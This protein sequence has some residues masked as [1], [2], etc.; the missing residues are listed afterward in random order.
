MKDNDD[1][2]RLL[3][4]FKFINIICIFD[5]FYKIYKFLYFYINY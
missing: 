3:I 4:F 2:E 5:L 1:K